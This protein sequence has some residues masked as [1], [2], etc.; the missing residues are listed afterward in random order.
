[1]N[2]GIACT[3]P[4]AFFGGLP[5]PARGLVQPHLHRGRDRPCPPLGPEVG[6]RDGVRGDGP[7]PRRAP[8]PGDNR[9]PATLVPGSPDVLPFPPPRPPVGPRRDVDLSAAP[10]PEVVAADLP[11]RHR[12]PHGADAQPPDAPARPVPPTPCH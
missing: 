11:Q 2:A 4:V 9:R 8:H 12:P 10:D 7:G 1:M 6:P 3:L 5:L